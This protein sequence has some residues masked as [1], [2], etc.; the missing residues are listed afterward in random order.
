MSQ[1]YSC[2]LIFMASYSNAIPFLLVLQGSNNFPQY[3]CMLSWKNPIKASNEGIFKLLA[4]TFFPLHTSQYTALLSPTWPICNVPSHLRFLFPASISPPT[5]LNQVVES[6]ANSMALVF[7]NPCLLPVSPAPHV[8]NS[9][10]S[11]GGE[12][13]HSPSLYTG[14]V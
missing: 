10:H 1:P 5:T 4:F 14:L 7:L 8:D 2:L 9:N 12:P 6:S 3:C 13:D 11:S